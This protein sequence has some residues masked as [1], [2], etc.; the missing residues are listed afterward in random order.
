MRCSCNVPLSVLPVHRLGCYAARAWCRI[1]GWEGPVVEIPCK[2]GPSVND[3]LML[4]RSSE[5]AIQAA[6]EA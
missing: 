5:A 1:C 4:Q 3:G 2:F 6:M